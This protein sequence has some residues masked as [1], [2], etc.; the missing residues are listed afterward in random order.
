MI[1]SRVVTA[2]AVLLVGCARTTASSAAVTPDVARSARAEIAATFAHGARAWNAGNLDDFLSDYYPDTSTTYI[3]RRGVL[4]G[5]EAI[6]GAYASRFGP[7]AQRDSLHFE[8]LEVDVLAPDLANAIAWYVLMRGDS[9]TARGPTSLLMR[10]RDGRWR[11][12]HDHS[13]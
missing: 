7:G 3:A 8:N 1:P 12:V 4:H 6:R 13:S 5:V 11:I 9:V 2:L 10:K